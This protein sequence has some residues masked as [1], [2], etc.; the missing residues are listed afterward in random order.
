[1][2]S[3]LLL[4]QHFFSH[5]G[6]YCDV[7]WEDMTLSP[8]S[9]MVSPF[10][11]W[12]YKWPMFQCPS[13]G[14]HWYTLVLHFSLGASCAKKSRE[15]RSDTPA[16][17]CSVPL[18]GFALFQKCPH[19]YSSGN[20]KHFPNSFLCSLMY[21][22]AQLALSSRNPGC[23][24]VWLYNQTPANPRNYRNGTLLH[25]LSPW[26]SDHQLFTASIFPPICSE[27]NG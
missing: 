5:P 11:L 26:Q 27:R 21:S 14:L 13:S 20:F 3:V 4:T 25:A 16:R 6:T 24:S 12:E 8:S 1:M 17:H 9:V 15:D 19:Y 7:R 18:S 22:H 10:S 2:S 23:D